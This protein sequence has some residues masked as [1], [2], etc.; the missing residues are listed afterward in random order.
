MSRD[1]QTTHTRDHHDQVRPVYADHA[2]SSP[3]RPAARAAWSEL[4]GI[5]G[6][7][8]ALHGAGRRVRAALEDAREELAALLGAHPDEVLFTAGGSEAD[9]IALLRAAE[10]WSG[11]RP[12]LLA[13]SIEHPAVGEA[14]RVLGERCARFAVDERGHADL[15]EVSELLARH[16]AGEVGLVSL[17]WVNNEVG[18][19]QPVRQAAEL[20]HRAG[21]WFH[22]DAVQA[23]GHLP[24]DFGALDAELL[25]VS[26]H[27]V[28]GP[29]GIGALLVRRG[30]QLGPYGLGGGQ[31][32]GIRS[33]TQMAALAAGFAAAARQADAERA[34]LTARLAGYR[35]RLV[36][37][38]SEIGGAVV[39]GAEP[40]S[41]AICNLGFAGASADDLTFLLDQQR[42]WC[43][44]G[45]A[46]RAGV[47]GPSEVLLAMG[48][49]EV[50]ARSGVRFSFGWS[51][52]D[53]DIDR[54]V[55]VLPSAVQ[56]VRAV[57][58]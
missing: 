44:T 30:V 43:S 22:T 45:S 14:A 56:Q 50:A 26:A 10:R 2:A 5:V 28:G 8:A 53:A 34:E 36:G 16:P 27:K 37:V 25:S 42:I 41:P 52:T 38:A 29:V 1:R 18:T 57:P 3:L 40:A 9:S 49:D 12:G 6:N 17:M 35:A 47:P 20:A 55:D 13:S 54:V 21:A 15:A 51:T 4:A 58:H 33:G 39:N 11:Q 32:G 19:V 46:C 24:I 7:P 23:L 48:R 31:E